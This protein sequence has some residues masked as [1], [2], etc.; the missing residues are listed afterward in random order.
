MFRLRREEVVH[1]YKSN[2]I[3]ELS[4]DVLIKKYQGISGSDALES[5]GYTMPRHVMNLVKDS[6]IT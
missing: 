6:S 4:N 3:I 1:L 2:G 5:A